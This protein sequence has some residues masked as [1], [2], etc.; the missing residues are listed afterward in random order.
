[1]LKADLHIHSRYSMDCT[2]PLEKIVERCRKLGITCVAIADHGTA[3]GGLKLREIAPFKVVV[4]EEILSTQGEIMGMFLSRTIPSGMSVPD[5]IA[6]IREQQGLV[7][8]PHPFDSIRGSALDSKALDEIA[9]Q[10][11]VIEVFNAR[12]PFPRNSEKARVFADK[13]GLA[14]SAGSDAHT[15]PEIGNAYVEM[16]D[17]NTKEEFLEALR[18][19]RIGGHQTGLLTHFASSFARVKSKLVNHPGRT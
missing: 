17:F 6:A 11:D 9:G 7:C 5:T 16:P 1:M 15:L 18:K 14:G 2:T 8:I 4:A 12:N 3:E 13:H 19:G 10:I